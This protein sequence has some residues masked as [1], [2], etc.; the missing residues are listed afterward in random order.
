MVDIF[1]LENDARYHAEKAVELDSKGKAEDAVFFY[2]EAAQSLISVRQQLVADQSKVTKTGLDIE[3][4]VRL[5]HNYV[6][7]AEAIKARL[8]SKP[9]ASIHL[10][11]SA[12]KGVERARYLLTQALDADEQ[13]NC[14]LAFKLYEEAVVLCLNERKSNPNGKIRDQ[15]KAIADQGKLIFLHDIPTVWRKRKIIEKSSVDGDDIVTIS[16]RTD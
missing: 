8:K 1:K 11:D 2:V 7:R 14:D 16:V 4:L 13:S 12:E 5:I 3:A 9:S 15:L 10:K 6:T